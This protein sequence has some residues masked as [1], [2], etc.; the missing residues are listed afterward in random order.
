VCARRRRPEGREIC[1]AEQRECAGTEGN[2]EGGNGAR[3]EVAPSRFRQG[4]R[5][6]HAALTHRPLLKDTAAT[7]WTAPSHDLRAGPMLRLRITREL[8]ACAHLQ[9]FII[10]NCV[11]FHSSLLRCF[12]HLSPVS[13]HTR[14]A[15]PYLHAK[16]LR[17]SRNHRNARRLDGSRTLGACD[18]LF[19][20]RYNQLCPN[21]LMVSFPRG[22]QTRI[23]TLRAPIPI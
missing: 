15:K 20:I 21:Q 14:P 22:F 13:A 16:R 1:S 4:L 7:T 10:L 3:A 2:H 6:R 12:A 11:R 23:R 18:P 8:H 19:V 5:G 17:M 9:H